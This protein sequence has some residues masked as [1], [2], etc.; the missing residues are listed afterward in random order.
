MYIN[1]VAVGTNTTMSLGPSSLGNTTQNWI[2]RSQY[3]ADPL[4]NSTV[5]EFQIYNHALSQAEVQTL[6]TSPGGTPGGGNVAWYRFDESGGAQAVDS[7]GNG[8]H[9]T[10]VTTF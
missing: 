2:G 9:G 10:V 5:D 3:A 8:R 6:T 1:G 4:L 7:S